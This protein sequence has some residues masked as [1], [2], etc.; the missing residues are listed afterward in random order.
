[1]PTTYS[2]KLRLSLMGTGEQA[3]TWGDVTNTNLGSLIEQAIAGYVTVSIVDSDSPSYSLVATDGAVD[4]ARSMAL[5]ITSSVT[6]T[7]TRS[8]ICPSKSKLYVVKNATTGG[9]SIILKTAAGSGITI[10]N[11][12]TNIVL[13]NGTSVVETLT[14]PA[15]G[16]TSLTTSSGLS[17]NTAATGAV[18]VTN[19]GV[20]GVTASTG[21]ST[22]AS[23]GSITLTNTGVTQITAGSGIS[24][25]GSTGNVTITSTGTGT[26]IPSGV[27]T[28]WSGS[29]ASIPS[30]WFL[31]NG[32]NG[33]PD[34]R[35]R[36]LV[37]AGSTYAVA[38]TGGSANA[39]LV[40]HSHTVSAS[41]TTAGAGGHSHGVSDPGHSHSVNDPGHTHTNTTG[42]QILSN[43]TAV[44]LSG[45]AN[46]GT[47]DG[48]AT[49]I[50]LNGALTGVSVNGVGDHTHSVSVAGNTSVD[51]S[52][53]TNAN[54]PPYYALAYI[55]KA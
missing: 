12:S 2:D 35:D 19:T 45:Y 16:V 34:L 53:A 50:S 26:S 41:G 51:G 36:F 29:I 39:T 28:M 6:L 31:C 1:M 48:A 11:G 52:S 49:G 40:S 20:I 14:L 47:T 10:P 3:G 30:G 54:L 8:V 55:M 27:I 44:F 32:S 7:A 23:T 5:N 43:G 15:T 9:Q 25:S 24:I 46:N 18:S 4:E 22:S 42:T 13:C 33:T 21:L 37:G 17:T 38:A